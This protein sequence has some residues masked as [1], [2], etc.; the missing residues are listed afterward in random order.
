MSIQS[1]NN[2]VPIISLTTDFGQKD[3]YVGAMQG[4]ILSICPRAVISTLS[5]DIPA[6]DVQAAAFVLYQA[7]GYYPPQ[8]VHCAVVDPGVGS[9]RRA[10]AVATSHGTFVGPDNGVFSLVLSAGQVDVIAAVSLT[11]P[12][13]QRPAVS[14]TFHGRDIFAPAAA[15]LAAG[16]PLAELGPPANDLVQLE[17]I[18]KSR[19]EDRQHAGRVIHIDRF[20]NII[21]DLTGAD[22]TDPRRIRFK[23]GDRLIESLSYTFAD[24]AEGEVLAYVGS[25]RDHIAI[26]LRNGNAARTLGIQLG[27]T[28]EISYGEKAIENCEA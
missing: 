15:H 6:Q 27:D 26:A 10:V 17:F 24:V 4:V 11:N 25:T 1:Q 16:V 5:H 22:I 14:A 2:P 7:C 3:G 23:V 9:E 28:I 19:Q 18:A 21:L 13:Y 8:A 20:G 12:A